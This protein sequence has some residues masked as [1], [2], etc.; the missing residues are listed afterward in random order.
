[1]ETLKNGRRKNPMLEQLGGKMHEYIPLLTGAFGALIGASASIAAMILQQ[2][3]QSRRERL[4]MAAKLAMDDYRLHHDFAPTLGKSV[5]IQ[6]VVVY[7]H[8]HT[9]IM[10]EIER[11]TLNPDTLRRIQEENVEMMGVIATMNKEM[12]EKAHNR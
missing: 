4:N 5:S 1:L 2:R 9:R 7:L 3:A 6:P 11:G 8:Y 12:G 10:D